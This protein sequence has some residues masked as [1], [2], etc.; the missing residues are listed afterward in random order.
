MET[1]KAA[2]LDELIDDVIL[3][4]EV[5]P[6]DTDPVLLEVEVVVDK[7]L[8]DSPPEWVDSLEQKSWTDTDVGY[9]A[10]DGVELLVTVVL[11][12]EG[13]LEVRLP[14]DEVDW[15]LF[16]KQDDFDAR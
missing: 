16:E 14:E 15:D 10:L 9:N 2:T 3:P 11:L 12:R 8:D 5:A 13:Y 7:E 1:E 6:E 4:Q